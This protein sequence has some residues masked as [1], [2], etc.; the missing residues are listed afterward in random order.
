LESAELG[1]IARL[2]R[3]T[4]ANAERDYL[5]ELLLFGLYSEVG[6]ELVFKGGTCM[7]KLHKLSRFSEDLDFT[8][9]KRIDI[10][11]AVERAINRL[12]FLDVYG[13]VKR[14]KK[15]PR[16]V[17]F[18]LL[19]R[20]PLYRGGRENLCFIPLNVSLRERVVLAPERATISSMYREI[21]SFDVFS[22]RV[23]EMLAEKVRAI[24]TRNKPRDL[25]DI[26]FLLEKGVQFDLGLVNKK[27]AI[28][29]MR[30]NLE[31][32]VARSN[33]MAKLW[34]VDLKNLVI[35]KLPEFEEVNNS[36]IKKFE[37]LV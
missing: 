22:M 12:R 29:K 17:N 5:Q 34:E 26:W 31:K 21:P 11:D 4:P 32:F 28:Q 13:R 19:F 2:K 10:E 6:P 16:E 36:V 27:L 7:Y 14:V 25:Y 30:F 18:G 3:L 33:E 1:E 15:H 8:L 20:G 24:F 23:E 35:G 9:A 37:T